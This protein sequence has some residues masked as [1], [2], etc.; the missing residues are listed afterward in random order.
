[1]RGVG[2]L[3]VLGVGV[4]GV[5]HRI[6]VMGVLSVDVRGVVHVD[7]P[8]AEFGVRGLGVIGVNML[9]VIHRV[10]M[11]GV[12]GDGVQ[13]HVSVVSVLGIGELCCC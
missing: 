1:M 13:R 9:D 12:L 6:G 7:H 3:S 11:L 8:N 4:L 5:R 2:E 10:G